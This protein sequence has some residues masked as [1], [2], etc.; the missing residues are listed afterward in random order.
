MLPHAPGRPTPYPRTAPD[1]RRT[2]VP[3]RAGAPL[4]TPPRAL[5][6]APGAMLGLAL[7]A[8]VGVALTVLGAGPS[9]AHNTLVSSDPADGSTPATAPAQ[10]TLTFNEPAVALGTVV[11]VRAPDGTVVSSGDAVLTDASVAQGLSGELPAGPYSVLWRV[12]SA[13]GHPIE[14]QLTFTAQG[15]TVVGGAPGSATTGP[16]AT[17]TAEPTATPTPTA[18]PSPTTTAPGASESAEPAE[19]D[20]EAEASATNALLAGT[21]AVLVALGV[22]VAVL[23]RRRPHGHDAGP[24]GTAPDGAPGTPDGSTG[25]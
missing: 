23:I 15:P 22:V 19:R 5:S 2:G 1:G 13:D 18:A 4:G 10:V 21:V 9:A 6:R 14:G 25:D 24:D 20:P 12:T 3:A 11:E 16:A 8:L 17:P 7:S